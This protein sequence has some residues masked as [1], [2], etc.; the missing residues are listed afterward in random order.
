MTGKPPTLIFF[1]SFPFNGRPARRRKTRNSL[2]DHKAIFHLARCRRGG[3]KCLVR[4]HDAFRCRLANN[5][6]CSFDLGSFGRRGKHGYSRLEEPTRKQS[7]SMVVH[8][9]NHGQSDR[10]DPPVYHLRCQ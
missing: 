10:T 9:A 7:S 3:K 8:D 4:P 1:L 5:T 6:K 2:D